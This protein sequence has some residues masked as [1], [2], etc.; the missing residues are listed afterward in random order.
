MPGRQQVGGGRVLTQR[1]ARAAN[2][3]ADQRKGA[4]PGAVLLNE[5]CEE[6]SVQGWWLGWEGP[7]Q[8]IPSQAA[9]ATQATFILSLSRAEDPDWGSGQLRLA[10]HRRTQGPSRPAFLLCRMAAPL[11]GHC[12]AQALGPSSLGTGKLGWEEGGGLPRLLPPGYS[13]I[14]G[15]A[16]L[17]PSAGNAG[18]C[19]AS[20]SGLVHGGHCGQTSPAWKPLCPAHAA[21]PPRTPLHST[22]TA[23]EPQLHARNP[24]QRLRHPTHHPARQGAP[25]MAPARG[26]SVLSC[27]HNMQRPPPS[28]T[29]STS[30]WPPDTPPS[31]ALTT[32][33]RPQPIHPSLP[34]LLHL[35]CPWP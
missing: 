20:L 14:S 4:R 10:Q 5:V 7:G 19:C 15:A 9:R 2:N 26:T 6:V 34:G 21:S 1:R 32:A 24:G 27:R 11:P 17:D 18:P 12:V 16:R 31:P 25:E 3:M 23:P 33:R 22:A 29:L 30:A 35:P 8:T 28:S 13:S